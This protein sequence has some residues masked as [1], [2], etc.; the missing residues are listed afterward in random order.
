MKEL[1]SI[2]FGIPED[3]IAFFNSEPKI[4]FLGQNKNI[5]V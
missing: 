4:K 3:K 5:P 1:K 2:S